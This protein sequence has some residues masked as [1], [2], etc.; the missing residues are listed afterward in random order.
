MENNPM[1]NIHSGKLGLLRTCEELVEGRW[2]P[3]TSMDFNVPI[4]VFSRKGGAQ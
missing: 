4:D 1:T 2:E 3:F